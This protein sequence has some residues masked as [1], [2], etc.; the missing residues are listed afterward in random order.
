MEGEKDWLEADNLGLVRKIYNIALTE[1]KDETWL[2]S[3]AEKLQRGTGHK[4]TIASLSWAWVRW[5][6]SKEGKG[7]EKY[8]RVVNVTLVSTDPFVRALEREVERL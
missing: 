4:I 8:S 7:E 5:G 1:K 6:N 2:I 3:S